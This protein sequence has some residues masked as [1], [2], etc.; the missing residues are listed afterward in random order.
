[1]Q[2]N[3]KFKIEKIMAYIFTQIFAQNSSPKNMRLKKI[4]EREAKG[5]GKFKSQND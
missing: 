2:N 3:A 5:N 1:M 4:K